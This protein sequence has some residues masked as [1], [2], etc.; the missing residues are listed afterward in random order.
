MASEP[1]FRNSRRERPS[2]VWWELLELIIS[3]G[4]STQFLLKFYT[5]KL[6]ARVLNLQF[7][8]LF[9]YI[10][11][12]K[13]SS[14]VQR[15]NSDRLKSHF[16]VVLDF[17]ILQFSHLKKLQRFFHVCKLLQHAW[18]DAQACKPMQFADSGTTVVVPAGCGR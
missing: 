4:C 18:D 14:I 2:H 12:I 9:H 17:A 10:Y 11:D 7:I 3:M 8:V 13:M 15:L 6:M 1:T 16:G 5:I